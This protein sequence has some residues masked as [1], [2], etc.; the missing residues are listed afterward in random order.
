VTPEQARSIFARLGGQK[1]FASFPG[2]GHE[3]LVVNT[4]Q[5][6]TGHVAR[7]LNGLSNTNR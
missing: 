7:F 1:E 6:W 5:A 4:E 3:T 2:A